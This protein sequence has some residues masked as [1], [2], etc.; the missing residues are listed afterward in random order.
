MKETGDYTGRYVSMNVGLRGKGQKPIDMFPRTDGF[1]NAPQTSIP[2]T[3]ANSFSSSFAQHTS[4][5][6]FIQFIQ[7]LHST[8]SFSTLH[9]ILS[10]STIIQRYRSALD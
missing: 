1:S 6:T 3:Q 2:S 5:D 8:L 10:F 7:H 9:L 4:F